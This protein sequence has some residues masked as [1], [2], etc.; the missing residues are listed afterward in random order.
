MNIG[1]VIRDKRTEKKL[2]LKDLAKATGLN[3]GYISQ[4]EVG[5]RENIS[6]NTV[7]KLA[8]HL[9]IDL[10]EL[11][12]FHSKGEETPEN[13]LYKLSN[14]LPT[15]LQVKNLSN[16]RASGFIYF[17]NKNIRGLFA[18][19]ADSAFFP[20][21]I[22]E[23]DVVILS[24]EIEPEPGDIILI[25]EKGSGLKFIRQKVKEM[26]DQEFIGTVLYL[27]RYLRWDIV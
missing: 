2:T 27:S 10:N 8:K 20:P 25:R 13:L 14:M 21:E 17:N 26:P 16:D 18:V 3:W 12:G 15:S 11:F 7:V 1:K 22:I 24:V 6:L 19:R 23:N 4:I 9:D 5:K